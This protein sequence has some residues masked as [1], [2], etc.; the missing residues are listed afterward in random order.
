MVPGPLGDANGISFRSMLR[1][2]MPYHVAVLFLVFEKTETPHAVVR[3]KNAMGTI[4]RGVRSPALSI[5]CVRIFSSFYSY[6]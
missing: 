2:E 1:N 5:F 3:I 6:F 4:R